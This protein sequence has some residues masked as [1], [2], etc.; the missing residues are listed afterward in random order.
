VTSLS[1]PHRKTDPNL[2]LVFVSACHSQ[3]AGR[4]FASAGARHVVAVRRSQEM[5]DIAAGTF[6]QQF[7]F[8]LVNG[9]TVQQAFDIARQSIDTQFQDNNYLANE[10]QKFVLLPR[11]ADHS[12]VLYLPRDDEEEKSSSTSSLVTDHTP[13]RGVA[14]FPPP[15]LS[16]WVGRY[17]DIHDLMHKVLSDQLT[18]ISCEK[19]L[20]KTAMLLRTVHYLWDRSLLAGIYYFDIYALLKKTPSLSIAEIVARAMFPRQR[21]GNSKRRNVHSSNV[22]TAQLIDAI[23]D[24]RARHPE[25]ADKAT[26]L[27][28]EDIDL[29]E[30][31]HLAEDQRIDVLVEDLLRGCPSVSLLLTLSTPTSQCSFL[32]S[33]DFRVV[34]LKPLSNE[35]SMRLLTAYLSKHFINM[36]R[37]KAHVQLDKVAAFCKG[38]PSLLKFA[39]AQFES[40]D[41]LG[42]LGNVNLRK[43]LREKV[44]AEYER[45]RM[46]RYWKELSLATG[47]LRIG[48]LK[49]H[50]RAR[51]GQQLWEEMYGRQARGLLDTLLWKMREWYRERVSDA[52]FKRR[53]IWTYYELEFIQLELL[54]F[55]AEQHKACSFK[56]PSEVVRGLEVAEADMTEEAPSVQSKK[57]KWYAVHKQLSGKSKKDKKGK[58]SKKNKG[59]FELNEVAEVS[60]EEKVPIE[61]FADFFRYWKD[62]WKTMMEPKVSRFYFAKDS[63]I[64][65]IAGMMKRGRAQSIIRAFAKGTFLIRFSKRDAASLVLVVSNGK[66]ATPSEFKVRI[67]TVRKIFPN[68]EEDEKKLKA[69]SKYTQTQSHT[70]EDE[71]CFCYQTVRKGM[72]QVETLY[73][74]LS[75]IHC[76]EHLWYKRRGNKQDS[77]VEKDKRKIL[78]YFK[79]RKDVLKDVWKFH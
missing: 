56:A 33:L 42:N 31:E 60:E 61:I 28:F 38:Y 59:T 69:S 66:G 63:E 71:I 55:L 1:D 6:T 67:Q 44:N 48:E 7:Y 40:E 32:K 73:E 12:A 76:L 70:A 46:R 10:S 45:L 26:L 2:R 50:I 27:I 9:K 37:I 54:P 58:G 39:A 29:F 65:L 79:G 47:R 51:D 19:G 43:Q 21:R 3:D 20:G 11:K 22:S 30:Y 8:A 16:E 36:G 17:H 62:L 24:R 25:H 15:I 74:V 35:D 4:A 78:K 49:K 41:D 57:R 5:H 77:F 52:Q 18:V 72:Q 75:E 64:T 68:E 34:R 14:S 23:K 13:K 53:P